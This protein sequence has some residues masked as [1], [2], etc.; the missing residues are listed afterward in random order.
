MDILY[1][2]FFLVHIFNTH[3]LK[4]YFEIECALN[5]TY[6]TCITS[7]IRIRVKTD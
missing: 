7:S 1:L 3:C 4:D 6:F 5:A 2:N